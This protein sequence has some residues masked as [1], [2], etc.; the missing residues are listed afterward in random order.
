MSEK[1]RFIE[2]DSRGR[3]SLSKATGDHELHQYYLVDV[4]P[5]GTIT[6]TPA[7]AVPK[8]LVSYEE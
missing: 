2:V 1:T 8:S 7:T 3:V 5:G 4:G 6:L